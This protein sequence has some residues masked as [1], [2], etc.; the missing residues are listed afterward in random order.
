MILLNEAFLFKGVWLALG[1]VLLHVSAFLVAWKREGEILSKGA[2]NWLMFTLGAVV[3]F[4]VGGFLLKVFSFTVSPSIFLVYWYTGG[5]VG[6]LPLLW[7]GR[8]EKKLPLR[9]L[10]K[11]SLASLGIIGSLATT[12]WALQLAPAGL[13]FPIFSFGSVLIPLLIGWMIFRERIELTL[14]RATGFAF[15]LAGLLAVIISQQ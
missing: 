9:D 8:Q 11:V 15:G 12:Y 14:I 5:F 13:V 6:F 7:M 4:G 2:K 10:W 3:I 1:I